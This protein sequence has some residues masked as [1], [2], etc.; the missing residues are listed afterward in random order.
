M[1]K[2]EFLTEMEL[3]VPWQALIELIEPL[4]R[5]RA[6][7]GGRSP[8]ATAVLQQPTE[9]GA[10]FLLTVKADPEDPEPADQ[11]SAAWQAQDPFLGNESRN[12]SG[13]WHQLDLRAEEA[14]DHIKE[15]WH[16]TN[17]IVE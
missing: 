16:G 17:G 14:P 1:A 3:V 7:P 8:H 5:W 2:R 13:P 4:T 10:D 9:Q 12:C 11:P 15:N 6:D